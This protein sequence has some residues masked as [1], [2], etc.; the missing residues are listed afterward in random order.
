MT[1]MKKVLLFA[2]IILSCNA[3]F[4]QMSVFMKMIE[5]KMLCN[6]EDQFT[7]FLQTNSYERKSGNHYLHYYNEGNNAYFVDIENENECYI[8]YKT[9]NVKDYNR[10][11]AR[12]TTACAKEYAKDKTVSFICN[13]MRVQDVQIIFVGYSTESEAYEIKVYQNPHS[14]ELPYNQSDRAVPGYEK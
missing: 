11:K 2:G 14:H 13:S 4:A 9:D 12:I 3:S 8:T 7:Y 1:F 10:I 6:K 5:N